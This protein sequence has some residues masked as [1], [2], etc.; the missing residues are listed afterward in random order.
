MLAFN[1]KESMIFFTTI[2]FCIIIIS[3]VVDE[4]KVVRILYRDLVVGGN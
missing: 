3:L 2:A 1:N 4:G